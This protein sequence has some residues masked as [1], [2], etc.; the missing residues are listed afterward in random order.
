MVV[1]LDAGHFHPTEVISDKISSLLLFV[2]EIMLQ[3][4][5]EFYGRAINEGYPNARVSGLWN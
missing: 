5:R 2:P 3:T 4:L 1:T